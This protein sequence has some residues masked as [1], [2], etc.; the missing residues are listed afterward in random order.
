[1][2]G[3]KRSWP[4][5]SNGEQYPGLARCQG[6][7]VLKLV[8]SLPG[9]VIDGQQRREAATQ[10]V[11][12]IS[13]DLWKLVVIDPILHQLVAGCGNRHQ[14]RK[15]CEKLLFDGAI[16]HRLLRAFDG[17]TWQRLIQAIAATGEAGPST[18]PPAPGSTE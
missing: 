4:A 10:L 2:E 18:I 15:S 7:Q 16:R 13:G 8:E 11:M 6:K 1:M 17:S 3:N 12:Q 14:S 9:A 5:N